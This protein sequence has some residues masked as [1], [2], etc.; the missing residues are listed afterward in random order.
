MDDTARAN[1]APCPE[2][3]AGHR[4]D[5]TPAVVSIPRVSAEQILQQM[6]EAYQRHPSRQLRLSLKNFAHYLGVRV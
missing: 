2:P 1:P 3:G 5:G 6:Q 4:P